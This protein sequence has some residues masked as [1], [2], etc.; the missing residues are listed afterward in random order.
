MSFLRLGVHCA[1]IDDDQHILL[2]RRDDL[3]VWNLPGGRLDAGEL[4]ADAAVRE[5]REETGVVVHI[6]RA[7]GL[8]YWV[9]WQRLNVIYAGWPLGG[10]LL[11]RTRETRANRYFAPNDVPATPWSLP[12]LDALAGTRHKP[13]VLE[14]SQVELRQTKLKLR[15]RWVRNALAGRREPAFPHFDVWAV[16]IIW[17]D[18]FRRVLTLPDFRA[19]ALPRVLCRGMVAPWQELGDMVHQR[20]GVYPSFRWVGLW[21]DASRN[22]IEFVFAATVKETELSADGEWT[23]TRN[24]ALGDRD[25]GYVER[26]KPTYA[27]DGVW[28]IIHE[29][30]V[31]HD[32][33]IDVKGESV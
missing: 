25:R 3:N 4:M 10:E 8:Y 6:E 24:T 21:Q 14:M 1:V 22:R 28:T 15:W 7:V 17:D 23:T 33:T 5:V 26:V 18:A 19:H 20:C 13:R 2:S 30:E 16:G 9:G 27:R 32:E 29:P 11:Q 12:V 31:R